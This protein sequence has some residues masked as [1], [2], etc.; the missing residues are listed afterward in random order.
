MK[1]HT[2]HTA[3]VRGE[4]S[5]FYASCMRYV[6]MCFQEADCHDLK[7]PEVGADSGF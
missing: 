1:D 3:S 4:V 6:E 2:K 5:A 7:W